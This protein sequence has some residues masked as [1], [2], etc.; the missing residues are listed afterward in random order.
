[1][2]PIVVHRH[3]LSGHCHRV[4]LMLSLLDLPASFVDVDFKTGAHKRPELLAKNPFGQLPVIEDGDAV[5]ADS[6]AILVYLVRRY[7]PGS[8]WLPEEPRAAAEVQRWLSVAAGPL[9]SGPATARAAAVFQTGQEVEAQRAAARL[10]FGRLDARLGASPFVAGSTPTIADIALYSYT[11]HAPEG[12]VSL[13]PFPNVRAWL[14]RIEALPRFV[15]MK[16][17]A[18]PEREQAA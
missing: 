14:A 7:A 13:A 5:I 17:T 16:A 12:G 8:A 11:A 2:N 4:E 9:A 10:L 1:M 15:P 6:N 18:T 3:P